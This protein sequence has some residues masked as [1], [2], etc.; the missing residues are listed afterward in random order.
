MAS[1]GSIGDYDFACMRGPI[2][3]PQMNRNVTQRAAVSGESVFFNGVHAA[4]FWLECCVDVAN[5]LAADYVSVWHQQA[6]ALQPQQLIMAGILK[7]GTYHILEVRPIGIYAASGSIGGIMGSG[8]RAVV[9]DAWRLKCVT[10]SE[11]PFS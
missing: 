2:A 5:L 7:P 11:N 10:P 8:A 3:Y 6:T 1:G 9:W 4:E